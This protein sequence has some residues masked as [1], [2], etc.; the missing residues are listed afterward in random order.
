MAGA[1]REGTARLGIPCFYNPRLMFLKYQPLVDYLS[2]QTGRKWELTLSM[3]YDR[4]VE[5]L[6]AGEI[7]VAYLGPF[8]YV[9][10]HERC[11][12][13]PVLHL[14]THGK[15]TYHGYI[16][17]RGDSP[18]RALGELRG[19]H[20]AF[21]TPLSTGSYLAA[22]EMLERAGLR[23]G[24][25]VGCH[26]YGQHERAV[27][28]VLLGEVDAC[29]VRDIVGEKF[30]PRG[31]RI[32]ATSPPLPN[33]PLVI[34]PSGVPELQDALVRALVVAPRDSEAASKAIAA[35]DEELAGGFAVAVDAE[36]EPI[37]R[38]ATQVFGPLALT[39]A[40][41]ELVC[42]GGGR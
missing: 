40:E 31:M 4:T 37:R 27:R 1:P 16:M 33:F 3:S 23:P 28:A 12:A 20:V 24:Q 34:A 26:F 41:T 42:G 8:S 11:G 10:A 6:C 32:L 19:R 14:M 35:W 38:L 30:V 2:A 5:A 9:R 22:A 15:D 39:A 21:G 18:I 29:A 36:F 17:V 25:D 7:D 13:V